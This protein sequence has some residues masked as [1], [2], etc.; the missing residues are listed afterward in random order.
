MIHGNQSGAIPRAARFGMGELAS[1]KDR[2]CNALAERVKRSP[3]VHLP[4][5]TN[6]GYMHDTLD[7]YYDAMRSKEYHGDLFDYMVYTLSG[8]IRPVILKYTSAKGVP[9]CELLVVPGLDGMPVTSTHYLFVIHYK[10]TKHYDLVHVDGLA[11]WPIGGEPQSSF[12]DALRI[13]ADLKRELLRAGLARG[14]KVPQSHDDGTRSFHD[15]T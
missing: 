3:T 1:L 5:L 12:D 11:T 10:G 15:H 13:P 8:D 4:M 2:L 6:C 9:K 7:G 14:I